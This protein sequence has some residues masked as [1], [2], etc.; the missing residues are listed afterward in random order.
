[1]SEAEK[2]NEIINKAA[3]LTYSGPWSLKPN[4]DTK[5]KKGADDGHQQPEQDKELLKTG[6]PEKG[7][8][9]M[10]DLN[11]MRGPK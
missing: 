3:N 10:E 2:K 8:P 11:G 7:V 5:S 6:L 4:R 9:K 1:M